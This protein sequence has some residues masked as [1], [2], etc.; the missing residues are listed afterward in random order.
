MTEQL[1]KLAGEVVRG[2][3]DQPALLAVMVLNV[4]ML[5]AGTWLITSLAK[6][7]QARFDLIFKA[8]LSK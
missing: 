6:A 3:Q 4:L 8:C 2:F 5:G 1:N 7:Q